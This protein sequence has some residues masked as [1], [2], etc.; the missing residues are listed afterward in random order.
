[1]TFATHAFLASASRKRSDVA[2]LITD[3]AGLAYTSGHYVEFDG[4]GDYA[5]VTPTFPS[6]VTDIELLARSTSDGSIPTTYG[7]GAFDANGT[8]Q[9]VSITTPAKEYGDKMWFDGVDDQINFGSFI[10]LTG[11]FRVRF[12]IF[13]TV[14]LEGHF[15]S[16]NVNTP[17]D[18][19]YCFSSGSCAIRIG[20]V[21]VGI[22]VIPKDNTVKQIEVKRIGSTVYLLI[23]GESVS[24][25]VLNTGNFTIN[26][27][28][29]LHASVTGVPR[30]KGTAWDFEFYDGATG[31]VHSYLGTG[32]TNSDWLDQTGSN[33]GT[34][35][36]S[37]QTVTQYF[38]TNPLEIGRSGSDYF[39]GDVANVNF[40]N[41]SGTIIGSWL[42]GSNDAGTLTGLPE[43][44][45]SGNGNHLTYTGCTSVVG[46]GLP[47]PQTGLLDWNKR[48]W[49]DGVDDNV[50]GVSIP[51]T[52]G[53]DISFYIMPVGVAGSPYAMSGSGDS[54][55]FSASYS[56]RL[57]V[58]S[59]NYS[60][61][62]GLE[63]YA[64]YLIRIVKSGGNVEIFV[65]G[66]S[67]GSKAVPDFTLT[68]IGGLGANYYKGLIYGITS[69]GLP[70]YNGGGISNSDWED[71]IGSNDGTVNGS[72]AE[73]LLPSSLSNPAVDALGNTIDD[74][75]NN[76][77][78]HTGWDGDRAVIP[79]DPALNVTTEAEWFIWGNFYID[80]GV[81]Q[82]KRFVDRWHA[83]NSQAVFLLARSTGDPAF[84]GKVRFYISTNGTSIAWSG[85][86]TVSNTHSLLRFQFIG[87][88][89]FR[90][91][92]YTSGSWTELTVT[93]EVG[94]LPA[95]L[96]SSDVPIY[97]PG[98][99]GTNP[100]EYWEGQQSPLFMYNR[101]LTDSEA[102]R[103]RRKTQ[104]T[105]GE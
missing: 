43:F 70:L 45:R 50:S 105:Y 98:T 69:G 3:P 28:G 68:Y 78:N 1:M 87:G 83:N 60:Y 27:I 67:L 23:D 44:D 34:V 13:S 2:G 56:V 55:R 49:F 22:G 61:G 54:I 99:Y 19:I 95:S 36:G 63:D 64:L 81:A 6:A 59:V 48:M 103:V 11:D 14:S 88:T 80:D 79:Y 32:V 39:A 93:T 12:K 51:I 52:N 102:D 91:W 97:L 77:L 7:T 29:D 66:S 85:S 37:P 9:N 72:P 24:S 90:V 74:P 46:E 31:L 89:S 76:L 73:I 25:G 20:S 16:N 84:D 38:S 47:V 17:G 15:V 94:S 58:S 65:N 104:S 33:D 5:S 40:K 30:L 21:Q 53:S 18:R 4:V 26:N 8:W 62:G 10:T 42:M 71:Q 75:R 100:L 96:Y 41:A 57:R 86:F 92:E 82:A 35:A 101:I